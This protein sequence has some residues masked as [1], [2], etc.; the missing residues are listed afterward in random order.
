[1]TLFMR[2]E[3]AVTC[4]WDTFMVGWEC[5]NAATHCIIDPTVTDDPEYPEGLHVAHLCDEHAPL[6]LCAMTAHV[7]SDDRYTDPDDY[8]V[9]EDADRG[10]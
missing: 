2:R 5:A 7:R 6:G 1:M 8:R 4:E 3:D 9:Q 10:K